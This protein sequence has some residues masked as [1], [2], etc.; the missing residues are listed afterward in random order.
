MPAPPWPTSQQKPGRSGAQPTTGTRS[1]ANV[2]RPA[3]DPPDRPQRQRRHFVQHL[4]SPR[5]VFHLRRGIDRFA[6]M[7]VGGRHQQASALGLEVAAAAGIHDERPGRH[8]RR[9]SDEAGRPAQGSQSERLD[10]SALGHDVSPRAGGVDDDV[11]IDDVGG[12]ADAPSSPCRLELERRC[13]PTDVGAALASTCGIRGE[14]QRDVQGAG[15]RL[16]QAAGLDRVSAATPAR[17]AALRRR[18]CAG[19]WERSPTQQRRRSRRAPSRHRC[20]R[21]TATHVG[22]TAGSRR[23]PQAAAR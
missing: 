4:E 6:R 11:R 5:H 9:S 18:R 3:H 7:L 21:S 10:T 2:R 20:A 8:V 23:T 22:G 15:V 12:C 16:P 14:E 19:P 17:C 13:S 1:G